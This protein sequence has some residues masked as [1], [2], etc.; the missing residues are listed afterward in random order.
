MKGGWSAVLLFCFTNLGMLCFLNS[1][2]S[3][4]ETGESIFKGK[5]AMCHGQDAAGD[6]NMGKMLKVPDLHSAEVQKRTEAELTEIVTKGKQKMPAY[7]GKLTKEQIEKVVAYIR[8]IG[9][10]H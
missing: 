1:P 6:T 4:Q 2:A 7:E 10:K 8:E 5:C 3:A 9:K